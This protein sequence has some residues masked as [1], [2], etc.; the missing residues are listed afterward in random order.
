MGAGGVS[1][2]MIHQNIKIEQPI[3]SYDSL[4]KFL[5]KVISHRVSGRAVEE[6]SPKI[7]G[8]CVTRQFMVFFPLSQTGKA[9]TI[10]RD[11]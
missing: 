11:D 8:V 6:V 5:Y 4:N 10:Q 3:Q 9:R 1:W 2:R 7:T